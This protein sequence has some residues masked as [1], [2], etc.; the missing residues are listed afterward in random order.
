MKN[1]IDFD[2][3]ES[4]ELVYF[5]AALSLF[6]SVVEISIPKPLPFFRLGLA[7]LP[8][9]I[10]LPLLKYRNFFILI[11][12]KSL[13]AS[14]LNGTLFSYLFV[15]SAG[16]SLVSASIMFF[17][18]YISSNRLSL[19]AISFSGAF[20]HTIV[21]V[22]LAALLIFGKSAYLFFL[23]MLI[24]GQTSSIFLGL[25]AS[26][27]VLPPLS[28]FKLEGAIN[29]NKQTTL[30]LRIIVLLFFGTIFVSF[31]LLSSPIYKFSGMIIMLMLSLLFSKKIKP[32]IFSSLSFLFILTINLLVR[33]GEVL[34]EYG[35]IQITEVS[36]F[37][38]IE[39]ASLF[40]G[41]IALSRLLFTSGLF[42][43]FS[44]GKIGEIFVWYRR[45]W[46]EPKLIISL[47]FKE[48]NKTSKIMHKT[49]LLF[50]NKDSSL[51]NNGKNYLVVTSLVLLLLLFV[52]LN[53]YSQLIQQP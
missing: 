51:K 50:K 25:I 47:L 35:F 9:L 4:L 44:I 22:L 10:G 30:L 2:K 27:T 20:I 53:V 17:L 43:C 42:D 11:V 34:F 6:L 3:K 18:F 21:Q 28:E 39:K 46:D 32:L 8:L 37:H 5:L 13:G 23:P 45:I 41:L 24:I 36:F 52:F 33:N 38:G 29:E 19:V 31:L 15:L 7:N 12:L 40:V 16:S 49:L 48:S 1:S 26:S 14:L